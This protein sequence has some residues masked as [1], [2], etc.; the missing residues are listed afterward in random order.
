MAPTAGLAIGE[1]ALDLEAVDS[2][3][4][5]QV[6]QRIDPLLCSIHAHEAA[7]R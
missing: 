6:E 1:T 2:F 4:A 3:L 7:Y 5:E